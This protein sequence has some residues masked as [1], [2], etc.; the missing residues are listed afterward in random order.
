[1]SSSQR[2]WLERLARFGY[3]AK[4]VVYFT[5]GLLAAA[6]A[7]NGGRPEGSGGA[8]QT[9]M[10]QPLGKAM[11]GLIGLG[12]VGYS[13]WR[14]TQAAKDTEHKGSD[15][16]GLAQRFGYAASGVI[17]LFLAFTCAEAALSNTNPGTSGSAQPWVA[18]LMNQ[19]FGQWL[20]GLLGVVLI[21]VG[22]FRLSTA[23]TKSFQNR[24][25]LEK[26]DQH[27][28]NLAVGAGQF[29]IAARAVVFGLTG[30][31]LIQAA[32]SANPQAAGSLEKVLSLIEQQGTWYLA[33]M[34][35]GLV[36]YAVYQGFLARYRHINAQPA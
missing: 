32:I 6:A 14:L 23:W 10:Q 25:H 9:I 24:F 21:G 1:M 16:S 5:V 2:D 3:G 35:F 22:L 7:W 36:A 13:F 27:E 4:G 29:G 33:L 8:L 20:V 19:P 26:M 31:F 28:R 15:A 11:L 34:A 18:E 30:Y 17:H 12:L